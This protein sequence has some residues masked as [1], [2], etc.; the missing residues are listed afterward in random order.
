MHQKISVW[1]FTEIK[2]SLEKQGL[3]LLFVVSYGC[4][5]LVIAEQYLLTLF[6][7]QS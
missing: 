5:G 3:V 1:L 7:E 6:S 2:I 4:L